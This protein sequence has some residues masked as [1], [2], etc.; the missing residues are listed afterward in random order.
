MLFGGT[1]YVYVQSLAPDL[2]HGPC[3]IENF[4]GQAAY[5]NNSFAELPANPTSYTGKYY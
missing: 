4:G 5:G 3:V 1:F 2:N